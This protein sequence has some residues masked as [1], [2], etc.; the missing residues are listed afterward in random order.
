MAKPKY[1]YKGKEFLDQIEALAKKGHTDTEIAITLGITPATFWENKAKY[2]AMSEALARA[3]AQV[4]AIVR[5]KYLATGLGGLKTKTITRRVIGGDVE[6]IIQEVE[7]EL[8]PNPSVLSQW[9]YAHDPEWKAMVDESKKLDITS[10]GKDLNPQIQVEIIDNRSQIEN[11]D[12]K[13][14]Q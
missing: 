4:N 14:L 1:N 3:R 10:N 13:D 8:P 7:A 2:P 6:D 11:T 9:L 5:Q 12:D